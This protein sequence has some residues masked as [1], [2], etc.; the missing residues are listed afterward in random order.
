MKPLSE[1]LQDLAQ[2]VKK[3][4]DSASAASRKNQAELSV[5]LYN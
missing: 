5:V 4:E 3:I 1:Q 2:R